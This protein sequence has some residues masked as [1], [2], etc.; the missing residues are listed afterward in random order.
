[1]KKGIL[2]ILLS[3]VLLTPLFTACQEE[4][5]LTGTK[6]SVYTLYTIVDERTTPESINQVE[7]ALNRILYY[8]LGVILKLEM[9]TEDEYDQ[10]IESKFAE[11]EELSENKKNNKTSTSNTESSAEVMTGDAILRLLEDGQEIPLDSPRLDIFL[12]QGYDNYAKFA[13]EGKLTAITEKLENEAKA[14]KS[15]I[16]T[17][18]FNAAKIQGKIYGIPANK[19]IGEYTYL[20]FDK[21]YLDKYSIDPN[22]IK[23][24]KDLQDY[25]SIIKENEPN[26]VPLKNIVQSSDINHLVT[27]GFPA[28]VTSNGNV[29]DAYNNKSLQEYLA[30]VAKY[31]SLGYL[32]NDNADENTKYAVRI[33]NGTTAEIEARLESTG[34]EYAYTLYSNP[35]ATNEN[36]IENI[37]CVSKYV[38]SNDLTAVMNILTAI[39]TDSQLMN[40]L[41]FGVENEH[42]VL[43]DN[44]QVE[45]LNETYIVK[46]ENIGNSFITYTL[47]GENPNKWDDAIAQ[48]IDAK[49]S[50]SLGYSMALTKFKY[51][52]LEKGDVEITE[53]NYIEIINPIIEKYYP[54]L[55]SGNAISFDYNQ[56]IA[57]ATA[58][59][60]LEIKT[61]LETHYIENIL[62]P[63]LNEQVRDEVTTT[64]SEE[65]R[66][67]AIQTIN[68]VYYEKTKSALKKE[69][70]ETFKKENPEATAEEISAMVDEKVTDALINE[71]LQSSAD[72][73]NT[74]VDEVYKNLLEKAVSDAA[75]A[76]VGSA[77]YNALYSQLIASED[78]ANEYAERLKYDAPSK[79]EAKADEKIALVLN[80]YTATIIAEI[81]TEVSNAVE[82][83]VAEYSEK[84][85]KS[86]EDILLAIGYLE[87]VEEGS[88]DNGEENPEDGASDAESSEVESSEAESSEIA[89]SSTEESPA[90]S[91]DSPAVSEGE[92]SEGEGT[93]DE[94]PV[95]IRVEKYESWWKFV[96]EEKIANSYYTLFPKAE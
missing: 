69:W 32:G 72:E 81:E 27:E 51:T 50:A 15:D 64:Q 70:Q 23:T 62:M 65:I 43:N 40:L 86:R 46:P 29:I 28:L 42:Y 37:F 94:A 38:V 44:K 17:T 34:R 75:N 55:I 95:I 67:K 4:V 31:Q 96:L 91:T 9:V 5:D 89:E 26:V 77:E 41:T 24:V 47:D 84:L 2:C 88:I 14:L 80:E 25:L 8:R 45:R 13:T 6:A 79:I 87:E 93:E 56:M 90:E 48:N 78:F 63:M 66:E 1:M 53:P 3:I 52:D 7:L 39:N 73:I 85:G 92:T 71:A 12:V 11:M 82:A 16:H 35:I 20:T 60:E 54:N 59:V 76:I 68:T 18:L 36:T 21:E 33:E 22:T 30:M 58:E 74:K 57:E 61:Q 49:Q 10:L 83:F 19:A